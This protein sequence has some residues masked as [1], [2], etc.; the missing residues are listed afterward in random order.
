MLTVSS[1]EFRFSEWGGVFSSLISPSTF[2]FSIFSQTPLKL[3]YVVGY[4]KK[5]GICN[6]FVIMLNL[7][8]IQLELER[9]KEKLR[10]VE[11]TIQKVE[12]KTFSNGPVRWVLLNLRYASMNVSHF[13]LP[14][15]FLKWSFV[16]CLNYM[17]LRVVNNYLNAFGNIFT[18]FVWVIRHVTRLSSVAF[19]CCMTR[20]KN[21]K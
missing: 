19:L 3:L 1:F 16:Y 12:G 11:E 9:A 4:K 2:F 17:K 13:A 8:R 10:N 18:G 20:I 6:V 15:N 21:V 14:V 5:S 7:S